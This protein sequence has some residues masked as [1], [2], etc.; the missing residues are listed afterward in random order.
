M[1]DKEL[2]DLFD[3]AFKAELIS[4]SGADENGYYLTVSKNTGGKLVVIYAGKHESCPFELM[5]QGYKEALDNL[6]DYYQKRD[7]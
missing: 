7:Y 4:M 6:E 2:I 1:I 3:S 5:R